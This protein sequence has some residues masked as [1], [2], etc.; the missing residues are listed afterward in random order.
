MSLNQ[1]PVVHN[2]AQES[3]DSSGEE[4]FDMAEDPN[5][6]VKGNKP[7]VPAIEDPNYFED[8][9]PEEIYDSFFNIRRMGFIAN[10][11]IRK[12]NETKHIVSS[13]ILEKRKKLKAVQRKQFEQLS[14]AGVEYL[15]VLLKMEI[16]ALKN[17][18]Q[19]V[20]EG[21]NPNTN[22]KCRLAHL[23]EDPNSAEILNKIY[24]TDSSIRTLEL[25]KTLAQDFVNNPIWQP[26]RLY[27]RIGD[28]RLIDVYPG[29]LSSESYSPESLRSVFSRL[30]I[31]FTRTVLKF[32]T[33]PK[34]TNSR[35]MLDAEFW[36]RYA[37]HDK[38]IYYIYQL[39]HDRS[40]AE[41]LMI[42]AALSRT[43]FDVELL[44]NNLVYASAA[45]SVHN[46]GLRSTSAGPTSGGPN[47]GGVG[48][49]SSSSS[50]AIVTGMKRDRE[51]AIAAE[52]HM[53]DESLEILELTGGGGGS[54]GVGS[55][56]VSSGGMLSVPGGVSG[57]VGI[58]SNGN[59][60]ITGPGGV[61]MTND[62][63]LKRARV[64]EFTGGSPEEISWQ[65]TV[66][67][68]RA[69]ANY[70]KR[71]SINNDIRFHQDMLTKENV[72]EA[73]KRNIK[74]KINMLLLKKVED[75]YDDLTF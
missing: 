48:G 32:Q 27:E 16:A 52:D 35:E 71:L 51:A 72:G 29:V 28:E 25:W 37:K 8:L 9:S 39:F 44:T 56:G 42:D 5:L 34:V 15:K 22:I 7:W 11:I 19:T 26:K 63:M 73:M 57:G 62:G 13:K 14:P 55:G 36:E 20:M 45:A 68:D 1:V 18:A 65:A 67:K 30:R 66:K 60:G 12:L 69:I 17:S 43:D 23:A 58:G 46:S 33:A 61:N 53:V 41:C 40:S 10:R 74:A 50:H 21:L 38:A 31:E 64:E 2:P 6:A 47:G 70:Y 4:N 59:G 49:P 3:D 75:R 54:N 24:A